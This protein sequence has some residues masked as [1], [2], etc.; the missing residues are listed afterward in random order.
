MRYSKDLDLE[1]IIVRNG[2]FT[3]QRRGLVGILACIL[4][5]GWATG[6]SGS[7]GPVLHRVAGK[8]NLA[9]QPVPNVMVHF[10]PVA[11]GHPSSGRTNA[12]G[13]FTLRHNAEREGAQAGDYKVWIQYLPKSPQEEM[14]IR[15]GKPPY[16]KE[17]EAALK[18]YGSEKGSPL[19]QS[20]QK[21][22][23]NLV[24]NLD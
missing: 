6:C 3:L 22:E 9:G 15:S 18:K 12:K 17:L 8:V 7:K 16:S 24:L 11:A 23:P 2:H 14:Q 13:E 19:S 1:G 4:F 21:A 5:C 10:E 20:V